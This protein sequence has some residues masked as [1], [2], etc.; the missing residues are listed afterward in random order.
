M[1]N[2]KKFN[3][4]L[5]AVVFISTVCLSVAFAPASLS[6]GKDAISGDYDL[7]KQGYWQI[8]KGLYP[9]AVKTLCQAAQADRNSVVPRR[10][11]ALALIRAGSGQAAIDQ[12]NLIGKMGPASPF[13]QYLYGEAYYDLER[14]TEAK[15]AYQQAVTAQGNFD[16]ARGGLI[17]S[18]VK[19]NQFDQAKATC[20][21]G[22]KQAKT[23]ETKKY[24]QAIFE[25]VQEISLNPS[26]NK[27]TQP[28]FQTS[29]ASTGPI[30]LGLRSS[31]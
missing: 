4:I 9:E 20:L 24:Y 21:Q 26:P 6:A 2:H 5:S 18:L 31:E 15:D 27:D 29:G 28:F 30:S 13:D 7:V 16:A 22:L 3:G 14:F 12:L 23:E 25:N 8:Q 10:Y 1:A 17:K 11:L 19:L